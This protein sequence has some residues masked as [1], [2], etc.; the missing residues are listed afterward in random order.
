MRLREFVRRYRDTLA[1]G[2]DSYVY[3]HAAPEPPN[4]YSL[5]DLEQWVNNYEPFYVWARSEGVKL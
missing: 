2:A 4:R 1:R 5:A 3:G